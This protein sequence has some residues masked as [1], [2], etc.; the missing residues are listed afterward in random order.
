[1]GT[2]ETSCWCGSARFTDSVH[3]QYHL[4]AACGSACLK[5]DHAQKDLHALYAADYWGSHQEQIG[6]PKIDRRAREDLPARCTYW[7]ETLLHYRT[8]PASLLEIGCAHGGFLRLAQSAGF[9]SLGVEMDDAIVELAKLWFGVNVVRGPLEE[10]SPPPGVF[11]VIVMLDVI[12]HLPAPAA[13]L[14]LITKHLAPNG[15]LMIQTPEFT[16]GREPS[17]MMFNAPEHIN[18]FS[19]PAML[20]LL[21]GLGLKHHAFEPPCF[22]TDMFV[23]ASRVPLP[24]IPAAKIDEA[25]LRTP[26][27]RV[28]LALLDAARKAREQESRMDVVRF[29]GVV[30]LAKLLFKAIRTWPA[31]RRQ[32]GSRG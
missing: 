10:I 14:A 1:M 23:I 18:L 32:R 7:L 22:S 21:G 27:G 12:E 13:S 6:L 30:G 15:V 20:G 26:E 31:R 8:P 3:P 29:Y 24:R 4:C 9:E 11:D 16:A 17:W 2:D 19:R 28:T 25:L 5:P